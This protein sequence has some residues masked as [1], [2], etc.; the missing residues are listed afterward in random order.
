MERTMQNHKFDDDGYIICPKCNGDINTIC[1]MCKGNGKIDWIAYAMKKETY[2]EPVDIFCNYM[3]RK[4]DREIMENIM[5][6]EKK[7]E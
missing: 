6:Q 5:N 2:S 7:E 4:I 1:F 3:I